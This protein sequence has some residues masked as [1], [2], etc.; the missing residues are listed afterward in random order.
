M[1]ALLGL[2]VILLLA[3]AVITFLSYLIMIFRIV[4]ECVLINKADG[5]WWKGLIPFY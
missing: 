2:A 1:A 4:V 5:N 3:T